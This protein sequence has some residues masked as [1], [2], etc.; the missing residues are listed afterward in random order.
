MTIELRNGQNNLISSH[1]S[2]ADAAEAQTWYD[3]DHVMELTYLW[4]TNDSCFVNDDGTPYPDGHGMYESSQ[5]PCH[6]VVRDPLGTLWIVPAI[7]SGWKSRTP[8]RGHKE[9]LNH[10]HPT[11]SIGLGIPGRT[12]SDH[13]S[14]KEAMALLHAE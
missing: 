10:V 7:A 12:T 9:S 13:I 2:L 3:E 1:D 14:A 4:D 8:Y 5:L 6:W 11:R